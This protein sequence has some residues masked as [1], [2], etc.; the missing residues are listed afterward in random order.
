MTGVDRSQLFRVNR[1]VVPA[2]DPT[3]TQYTNTLVYDLGTGAGVAANTNF[4]VNGLAYNPRDG[5]LY[6]LTYPVS[7]TGFPVVNLYRI[8]QGGVENLGTITIGGAAPTGNYPQFAAGVIDQNGFYY[9]APRNL[10]DASYQSSLFRF[11]LNQATNANKRNATV[12]PMRFYVS[13]APTTQVAPTNTTDFSFID[14][15]FNPADNTLYGV[16]GLGT[17]YKFDFT[18]TAGVARVTRT[19]P[20]PDGT[21]N[22][23]SAS[24]D[25]SGNFYA[26]SNEGNFYSINT[27]TGAATDIGDVPTA[28]VTDGASCVNPDQRLD[29]VKEVT[30]VTA[31]NA[32]TYNVSFAIRVKNTG[33]VTTTNVQVSDFL[34]GS[35]TNS[36]FPT[37]SSVTV[38]N[39]AVANAGG[40][41]AVNTAFTGQG[42]NADLLT[43]N[44]SLT[45]GQSAT[46]TFTAQVVYPTGSVPTTAQNNTAYASSVAGTTT[47]P[48]YS[49]QGN[50]TLIVPPGDLLAVD[51]STNSASLPTT[52]NGDTP[53]PSP[54]YF[55][56]AILGNVFEDFNY[57]GGA[58]RSQAT[59]QGLATVAGTRVELYSAGLTAA[60]QRLIA[61]TTTDAAGNYRFVDGQNNGAGT[62]LDLSSNTSYIVRV[63]S[64]SAASQRLNSGVTASTLIPVQTFVS[65]GV[66]ND[67]ERVGGENNTLAEAG[68]GTT[69][70]NGTSSG[71]TIASLTGTAAVPQSITT[72]TLPASG[73][74]VGV[75][76]GFNFSTIINTNASGRGS[77]S[78]FI[79]NANGLS[80]TGLAQVGQT[81]GV[82]T[83]IFMIYNGADV[84]GYTA[85]RTGLTDM[86]DANGVA[87]ITQTADLPFLSDAN[88]SI[89]GTTQTANIGNSNTGTLGVGGTVGTAATALSTVNQPEIQIVGSTA[90]LIGLDVRSTA[91]NTRIEGISIYGFGNTPDND[92]SANI[93]VAADNTTITGSVIGNTANN[94]TTAP[95]TATNA[96]NIRVIGGTDVQI[97]NNLIGFA[98]GKG[99]AIKLGVT[100]TTVTNNEIR[101]NAN[102]P[103]FYYL[104]G[105]D[106]QGNNATITNNLIINNRGNGIDSYNGG[107]NHTITGNTITGNGGGNSETAA[108]RL[109]GS[110]STVGNNI[111]N[112]NFGA[113]ILGTS[114]SN[115]NTFTQNSIFANGTVLSVG[116]SAATYQIGIDLLGTTDNSATGT[117]NYVTLNDNNGTTNDI[118]AGGNGLLNFPVIQTATIRNGNLI[119]TGFAT[120]GSNLEFFLAANDDSGFG[121]GQ[122]YLFS[123]VEG[124]GNDL[125]A[126]TG[127]YSGLINGLN[128][129]AEVN[130]SRFTFSIPLSSLTAT[131][132]SALNAG[133]ALLTA[134]ATVTGT[135]TSEFSGNVPVRSAPV[136]ANDQAVTGPGTAVTLNVAGNDQ[137]SIDAA[138]INL[139]AQGIGNSY[140]VAGQGTFTWASS[141]QIAF[142]PAA[143]FTGIVTIPYTINNTSGNTSNTAFITVEVR[144]PNADLQATITGPLNNTAINGGASLNYTVVATNNTAGITATGVVE[145]L[146]LPAGLTS[147]GGTVTIGNGANAAAATYNNTTGLVTIPVGTLINGFPQ[148][149]AVTVSNMPGSGPITATANISGAVTE[150]NTTNN[151]AATTVTINPRYDVATTISGPTAGVVR[152]NEVT[153]TVTTSNLSTTSGSVS[154]AT[155]VVQT[156]QLPAGLTGVFASNGGTYDAASGVVTFP[157]IG[158]LPVGQ[159]V[160]NS[161]SFAA[162]TT[163]TSFVSP[164]ATVTASTNNPGDLNTVNNSAF[165]NGAAALGNVATTAP[166]GT[167]AAPGTAQ[168][169]TVANVYTNVTS[170]AAN[171]APGAPVTLTV[172]TGNAGPNAAGTVAQ[173]LLLPANLTGVTVTN[174]TYA[175]STGLVTFSS[176][177]TLNPGTTNTTGGNNLPF[178]VSFTAPAQGFVLATAT[179]TSATTDVVPADN[180]AQ[181]KVEVNPVADL[182]TVLAGPST[183]STGQQVTYTVTT[184]NNGGEAA[185]GTVQRVTLPAGLTNVTVSN[186]GSYDANTGIVT[187]NIAGTLAQG[188]LQTNSVSYAVPTGATSFTAT[189]SVSSSTPE[190]VLTNNTATVYTTVLATADVTV[191]VAG[192]ATGLV[193]SPVVYAVTT[194]N[195]GPSPA[196]SVVPT[197]QLP[198]GLTNNGTVTVYGGGSYDNA[199][200]LV[201]F[202]I[203]SLPSGRSVSNSVILTVPDVT[204][205]NG[206]ARVSSAAAETNYDNNFASVVTTISPATAAVANLGTTIG[207]SATSVGPGT[208]VTLTANF[209]NAAGAGAA[210]AVVP[211]LYLPAGLTSNGNTVTVVGGTNGSYNNMT[212]VVTWSSPGDLAGGASLPANTYR[213][214]FVAPNSG[215]ITASSV[216]NSSTSDSAPANNVAST[217]ITVNPSANV[218]TG[219]SGPAIVQSG[220]PVTYAVTTLNNGGS[221]ASSTQAVTLPAGATNIT[222]SGA[223]GPVTAANGTTTIT[224][225]AISSQAVGA[226]GQVTNYVSF[227]APAADFTVTANLTPGTT[228]GDV[229][230]DNTASVTTRINRAPVAY[231]VVNNLQTPQ[232]NTAGSLGLSP[233]VATDADGNTLTYNITSLPATAAGTLYVGT[234]L[235]STS[236]PLTAAQINALRFDPAA[237]FIGNAFFSYTATDNAATPATSNTAIYTI[238]VGQDASSVYTST[239]KG[240]S[241]ATAYQNGDLIAAV[242]DANASRSN[243]SGVVYDYA[244]VNANGSTGKLVGTENGVRSATTDTNGAATLSL[245]GLTLD[246]VTGEIRVQDRTKLALRSGTYSLNVT[247]VDVNGGTNAQTVSFTIGFGPLPVTLVEFGVKAQN[248]DAL[249]T[250]TTAQEKDNDHFDVERSLDGRTFEKVGEVA[251]HGTVSNAQHY[252]FTDANAAR[253]GQL[254]YYRLRQVDFDRA[255]SY[256]AIQ[257]VSFGQLTTVELTL[258]PN[259]A[260]EVLNVRLSGPATQA[261]VT[262]YSATGALVLKGQLDGSLSTI[263]D[264]RALPAGTYLVKVQAANG[265]PLT[266]RFVKH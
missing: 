77:L 188:Q 261:A 255:D 45:A 224:F 121:E 176:I 221:P 182:A 140:T 15:G 85:P 149:Y 200:G 100:N 135:G 186:G 82:E 8:G 75:D 79:T 5:Y 29:V 199:T 142:T 93:R 240:G 30:G 2:A 53:S 42:A 152:G 174:G 39:L 65:N 90:R 27:S 101:Q 131:Q 191:A 241:T 1:N 205:I 28:S 257:S 66:T 59:S 234:T 13:T 165:L 12:I 106:A 132:Q 207:A 67:T 157:T 127:S 160:V 233:L 228:T 104:D 259:P 108:I 40:S 84:A 171:V 195:N 61:V 113:G 147:N 41:L 260:T 126:G 129:G 116:G 9:A 112:A 204:Q 54:V 264:V 187:F 229:T 194:T 156:V 35:A 37:S 99:V 146:Q 4:V 244:A 110:G 111:I 118:D 148:T 167:P 14:L 69:I 252:R 247:T 236:T 98:N 34:R 94:F 210:T 130:Q 183:V 117:P 3:T 262:V 102:I 144:N 151:T 6:A 136:A 26:Y 250:W 263:L 81:A 154:T 218:S 242:A 185:V 103:A 83:S 76:F 32:T 175:P 24:F 22:L 198:A 220:A 50:G 33:T 246:P 91:I 58:G 158:T 192:P 231:N 213:V 20:V 143:G 180:L 60:L 11:D 164:S 44:Q 248:N 150:T 215:S 51:A 114:G 96:D 245:L 170:P 72:V 258:F 251:G 56:P 223:N 209:S 211:T 25:V 201:T 97:S 230:T 89:D 139:A 36:T 105:I 23:G 206:V 203:V 217:T 88:T 184:T 237:G 123:R 78:Q 163:G 225:P 238:A 256:S 19:G 21:V 141:G 190:T 208:S 145:T 63:V 193:G 173:T 162:P 86:V 122:T 138:S 239:V 109:F 17:I 219:I 137:N 134:T 10:A 87:V 235:V 166:T 47:N 222:Y 125:N 178:T 68:N 48:G 254:V 128:Q 266:R 168:T 120:A 124:S 115:N 172:T 74:R 119:L 31:V 179:V 95:G 107:S 153:Y 181:T 64:T 92:G 243:T 43:G 189:A 249:L 70:G 38:S 71:T 177:A 226:A 197:L 202:S 232:A 214:T 212:G 57:G 216:I 49:L 159:T 227:T 133:T 265:L 80:N 46:I 18:T 62:A 161:I 7:N 16:Y 73:P 55:T 52:P 155:N 253:L 196:T 169:G